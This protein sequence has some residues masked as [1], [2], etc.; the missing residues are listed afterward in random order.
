MANK[1]VLTIYIDTVIKRRLSEIKKKTGIPMG[2]VIEQALEKELPAF[3]K[4]YGIN[5]KMKF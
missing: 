5:T 4:D 2:R 3:E 1:T